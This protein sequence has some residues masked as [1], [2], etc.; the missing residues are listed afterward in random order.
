MANEI[1]IS[2]S[3]AL[4]NGTL[5]QAVS[6]SDSVDQAA[7]LAM[8]K[9]VAVSHSAEADVDLSPVTTNGFVFMQ[10]TDSTNFIKFGPKSGGVMVELGRLK[11]GEVACF[12]LASGVTLRW[13][14]DTASVTVALWAWNN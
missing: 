11:P 6:L 13:V 3:A 1:S 2:V 4:A 9:T 8:F 10:N 7:A 12:R 5:S 14:A